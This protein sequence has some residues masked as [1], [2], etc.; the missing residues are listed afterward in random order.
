MS[1]KSIIDISLHLKK[2]RNIDLY[3]QGVYFIKIK[4][5][6]DNS[7]NKNKKSPDPNKKLK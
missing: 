6:I 5:K 2:F 3:K 1:L 7:P 4:L